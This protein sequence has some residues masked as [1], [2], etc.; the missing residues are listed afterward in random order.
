MPLQV[1]LRLKAYKCHKTVTSKFIT[2]SSN[3]NKMERQEG[4][5]NADAKLNVCEGNQLV[6][7]Y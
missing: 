6:T 4:P 3:N 2:Y 1:A 7:N 5:A